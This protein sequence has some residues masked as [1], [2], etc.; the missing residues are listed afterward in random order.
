MGGAIAMGAIGQ[1]VVAAKDVTISHLSD[2][3]KPLFG[4]LAEQV[5]ID[6]EN[7]RNIIGADYI[8]IAVKPWLLEEVLTQICHNIDRSHQSIIS[9][10]AGVSFERLSQMLKC[11]SLGSLPLYRVIPNTAISIGK[12]VSII[13]SHNSTPQGDKNVE[14]IFTALGETFCVEEPLITPLTSLA[15]CG[16]AFALRYLDAAA[17]AGAQVGIDPT[18]SLQVTLK[19]MEGAIAMLQ[20]NQSAPQEEIDK[21]TT[22]GGITLKGLEAMERDGFS[23][24]V[25]SAIKESR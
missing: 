11:D 1:G 9:V 21:V 3:M 6:N 10:V 12:G 7:D 13:S 24:A 2:K 17:A 19:T 15:S 4:P 16:I 20:T 23:A 18:M 5:A 14:Q 22:K 25:G 8:I